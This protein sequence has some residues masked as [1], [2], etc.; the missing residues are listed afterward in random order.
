[1]DG[2]SGG[3]PRIPVEAEADLFASYFLLPEKPLRKAFEQKFLT[4]RFVLD[5]DTAFALNSKSL[6]FVRSRCRTLRDLTRILADAEYYNGVRFDSLAKQFRV[7]ID[8]MAIR[9]EELG[10]VEP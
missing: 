1:L 7:S 10:L 2:S 8:A 5:D 6:N 4:Q 9:L 3:A